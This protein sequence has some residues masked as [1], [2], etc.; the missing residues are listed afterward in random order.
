MFIIREVICLGLG[1]LFLGK[2][3]TETVFFYMYLYVSNLKLKQIYHLWETHEI[4]L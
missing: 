1:V 3:D 4:Y 2:E